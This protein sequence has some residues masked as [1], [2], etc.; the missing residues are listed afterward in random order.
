MRKI[1]VLD[2]VYDLITINMEDRFKDNVAFRFYD[3]ANDAVTTILYKD[4]CAGYPQGGELLPVHHPGDQGQKD[5]PAHQEQLRVC[6]EHL[7]RGGGRC[8][9]GAAE[10]AQELGR[11][12]LRAG[13]C[14]AGRILTDGDDYGFND[15]LKAAY[16]DIL[17]PMDGFRSYEPAQLTRCIDHEA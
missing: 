17:R 12:E 16:G 3:T 11:A 8:G 15:Q 10:P 7:W 1:R 13:P 9:A 4:Y 5:L 14:G 2:N 6:R